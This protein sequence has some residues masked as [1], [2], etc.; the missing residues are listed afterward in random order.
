MV[1][2]FPLSR[3]EVAHGLSQNAVR[4]SLHWRPTQRPTLQFSV[5][6]S[7]PHRCVRYGRQ[8]AAGKCRTHAVVQQRMLARMPV[9]LLKA[10]VCIGENLA[11]LV[12]VLLC[13]WS[14]LSA[15]T[16]ATGARIQPTC[17]R[18]FIQLTDTI[19]LEA[20]ETAVRVTKTSQISR[21]KNWHRP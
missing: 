16:V 13:P 3:S 1:H 4:T 18:R 5:I 21:K 6:T 10:Y 14:L 2:V 9:L 19:S 17:R 7:K 15:D 20:Q 8:Q 12:G 11:G